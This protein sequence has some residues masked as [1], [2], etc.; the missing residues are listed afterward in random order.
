[1]DIFSGD[2]KDNQLIDLFIELLDQFSDN[3]IVIFLEDL[4]WLD[5]GSW[6][7]IFEII[8][9]I[10]P[11]VLVMTSRSINH[12]SYQRLVSSCIITLPLASLSEEDTILLIQR[13][14]KVTEQIP[15]QIVRLIY[16]TCGGNPYFS[17]T[18]QFFFFFIQFNSFF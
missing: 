9:K 3:P 5:S 16:D 18:N 14:L 2:S 12:L 6:S 10:T 4:H 15:Q 8:Q 11:I 13:H 7:L 17:V 1:M